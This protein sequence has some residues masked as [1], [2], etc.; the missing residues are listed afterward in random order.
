LANIYREFGM[1]LGGWQFVDCGLGLVHHANLLFFANNSKFEKS[2]KNFFRV[3]PQEGVEGLLHS[4]VS[5]YPHPLF[6]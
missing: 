6:F 3:G 2:H 4:G 5:P 1:R